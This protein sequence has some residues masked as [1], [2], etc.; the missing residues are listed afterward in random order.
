MGKRLIILSGIIL[1]MILL[2]AGNIMA[3]TYYVSNSGDNGN[4]GTSKATPWRTLAYLNT[5]T[6]A[7]GDSILFEAGGIWRETL[8]IQ[9]SGNKTNPIV[10]SSYGIGKNPAIY[11]SN[12]AINWT[13]TG[14]ANVWQTGTAL[15]NFSQE[16][17][18]AR[19]FFIEN[20]SVS[21]GRFRTYSEGFTNLIQDLDYTVSG[22]VHYIYSTTDPNT[23][24]ESVEVTQ[25]SY[26]IQT[27][28]TSYLHLI[29]IDLKFARLSGFFAGYPEY[30]GVAGLV[31]KNCNIAYIGS[32]GSGYAYGIE[33]WHSNSLIENCNFSDCGRRAI[34]MNLYSA[35]F[36]AGQERVVDN[37]IIRNN[38]FKRGYH[39]TGLDLACNR[40]A[41][42]TI[43]NIY[44]YNNLH[45]DSEFDAIGNGLTSNQA[46]IYTVAGDYVNNIVIAN[47]IF[48]Q[49]TARSILTMGCD[50]IRM[51]HNN[52][53]GH[54]P[55]I[56]EHPYGNVALN[57]TKRVDYRNNILYDN[58]PNNNLYNYGLHAWNSNTDYF[59]RDNNLYFSENPKTDRCFTSVF[60]KSENR[61]YYYTTA[62][63]NNFRTKFPDLEI[64]SPMPQN[65]QFI[66]YGQNDFRLGENSP[67]INAG[68]MLPYVVVTDPYGVKDTLNKYDYNG[69][70]RNR[71]T[72]SIGAFD[73]LPDAGENDILYF[74]LP[75][76]SSQAAINSTNHTVSIVVAKGTDVSKLTPSIVVS[77][78]ASIS[79]ASGVQRNF[80]TAQDYTVT[81]SDGTPQ[82][83][84]VTVT[85]GSS[86][87]NDITAFT[88]SGQEGASTINATAHT[89]T[90]NVP[91]GTNITSLAPTITV[92]ADATISP[93]TGV[94][95]NFT[96]PQTYTVTAENGSTQSWTVTVVVGEQPP[97]EENNLPV[98]ELSYEQTALKGLVYTLDASDSY[99]ADN[100]PLS[101][102]WS[103][104][105]EF[106]VSSLT[107]PVV[108]I[109]P[110]ENTSERV[111]NLVLSVS[112]GKATVQS[113][114]SIGVYRFNPNA[115]E[116]NVVAIEASDYEAGN[117][118]EKII[119]NDQQTRWSAD[120]DNQYLI[121]ELEKQAFVSHF[122]VS[123]HSGESRTSYFDIYAS[124]DQAEWELI[125]NNSTSCGFSPNM[126]T[127]GFPETKSSVKYKY[128]KLVG[129]MNSENTWNSYNELKIFGEYA[130]TSPVQGQA[131]ND[132][133]FEVFPNPS[134]GEVFVRTGKESSLKVISL[135]GNVL[136]E[137][138][139]L[140]DISKIDYSFSTPGMYYIVIT[141]TNN[142]T[143]TQK[144]IIK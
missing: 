52:I 96:T 77:Y 31:F 10:Y 103:I 48:I 69:N 128:I 39:T 8:R 74:E 11:G 107:E 98:I 112:D 4:N 85:V 5:K 105:A 87:A 91:Y 22:N 136:Y 78:Q 133:N 123:F 47:N 30:R 117:E 114:F 134:F 37:V 50:T 120:G 32:K 19:M 36:P 139:N 67:A 104:P 15:T 53:I 94:A 56:T 59:Q 131:K 71:A 137:Q 33:I 68:T 118:P 142:N 113:N 125:L 35:N 38:T 80:T 1:S 83:W 28:R 101:F 76:Q 46:F 51:W 95:R 135:T 23:Q 42:D 141:D 73:V 129:R 63:W 34:S 111:Y 9:Q 124:N 126:H 88:V 132:S 17:Y 72:P 106:S 44:Y 92:S 90:V 86:S 138:E 93:A 43:R 110:T 127:F 109:L 99:D 62:V 21:W 57:G 55:N 116:L 6:F 84:T 79:P 82:V 41:G 65:P 7:P 70:I 2:G 54:N 122:E 16:Y 108:S 20:D 81:A 130:T 18:S 64:N 24:Y 40:G 12:Q 49:A 26:C 29:G 97:V 61:N 45:D 25:R 27:D 119:D 14:T 143:Y 115:V 121:F 13:P 100:E 58:L 75:Q 144:L 140:V 102:S 89:V 60:V 3:T 66:N